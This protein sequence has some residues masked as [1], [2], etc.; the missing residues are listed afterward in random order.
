MM[1]HGALSPPWV[2]EWQICSLEF[3]TWPDYPLNDVS[4][5][6][7]C[8][9]F[10]HTSPPKGGRLKT[11]PFNLFLTYFQE[12][13]HP[14]KGSIQSFAEP[15]GIA[16]KSIKV[17]VYFKKIYTEHF[18]DT[19]FFFFFFQWLGFKW[20]PQ[21]RVDCFLLNPLS[22]HAAKLPYCKPS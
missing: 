16:R 15:L 4:L 14:C 17:R 19:V 22:C 13:F 11:I 20:I 12:N 21:K 9:L 7:S 5:F 6:S 3:F 18:S 2:R 1:I 10:H 8:S